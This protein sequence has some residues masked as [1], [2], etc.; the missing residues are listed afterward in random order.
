[1]YVL[2]LEKD[3]PCIKTQ[4]IL[5]SNKVKTLHVITDRQ[6]RSVG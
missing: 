3:D 6:N 4:V 2:L 5:I 1:M